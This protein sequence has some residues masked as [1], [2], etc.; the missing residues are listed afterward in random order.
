LWVRI[1]AGLLPG[2]SLGQ[3]AD[4]HVPLSPSSVIWSWP[5]VSDSSAGKVTAGLVESNGSLSLGGWLKK[6]AVS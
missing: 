6:S 3:A 1:S 5:M 2:N 4:M